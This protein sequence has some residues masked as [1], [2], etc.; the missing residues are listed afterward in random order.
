MRLVASGSIGQFCGSCCVNCCNFRVAKRGLDLV[1]RDLLQVSY[2]LV[3]RVVS[4]VARFDEG[5]F[6]FVASRMAF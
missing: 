3:L 1:L 2:H 4:R 5:R 6:A